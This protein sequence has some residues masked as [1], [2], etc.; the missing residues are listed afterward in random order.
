MKNKLFLYHFFHLVMALLLSLVITVIYYKAN[1]GNIDPYDQFIYGDTINASYSKLTDYR[2][3]PILFSL[4]VFSFIIFDKLKVIQNCAHKYSSVKEKLQSVK[5]NKLLNFILNFLLV[6][7]FSYLSSNVLFSIIGGEYYSIFNRNV[8]IISIMVIS[9]PLKQRAPLVSQLFFSFSPL[10]YLNESYIFNGNAIHFPPSDELSYLIYFISLITLIISI[11]NVMKNNSKINFS[12]LVFVCVTLIGEGSRVYALDEYHLGEIFTNFHQGITLNQSYY[13]EYIPTKGF[14]HTFV[15]ILNNTFYDGGYT[16]IAL[17]SKLSALIT[18]ILLLS[19]LSFFYSNLVILILL[20][21]GLPLTGNYAPILVGICILSSKR[22]MNNSYNFLIMSLFF[23]FVYFIY[24]NAFSAAFGLAIFPVLIYHLKE[25]FTHKYRPKKSHLILSI[26]GVFTF[27]ISF[28]YIIASLS[29]ILSNS[30]SNL[31][32]WGNSGTFEAL[33]T[34]NLWVLIPIALSFLIYTKVLVINR[35]NILWVCFFI[36]FPFAIL[37]YL[38]GRADGR[39][40]RALGFTFFI[41][42]M[43]FAFI[44]SKSIELNKISKCVLSAIFI[45]LLITT[46]NPVFNKIR[47]VDN[48]YHIFSI[49]HIGNNHVVI[50]KGEIPNLG[51]G[52]IEKRRYQDL[53]NEYSLISKLS[54]DET[55]LIIDGYVTQSARYSIFDKLIPTL[56]HSVLNISS[57]KAQSKE[58]VKIKKSN[59]KIIR[60]SNG[61]KRYHLFFNYF[62]SLN[63]KFI[64]FK[65]RDYLVAPELLSN[66]ENKLDFIIKSSFEQQYS[67]KQFGLL[68]IKWGN[69]LNNQLPNLKYVRV[70]EKFS[71]SNSINTSNYIDGND[72]WFAYDVNNHLEPLSLDLINLNFSINKGITCDSQLFWDDGNGFNEVKSMRF[73]I[74]NGN[75][76]IPAHMNFDWRGSD[77]IL[78]IR[79]DIDNCNKKEVSLN[80]IGAYKYNFQN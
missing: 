15:G 17:S 30:S 8:F 20:L 22:V 47:N 9:L 56:S 12:F 79:I 57:L 10:V 36:I 13:S 41:A 1:I 46:K 48:F 45:I 26:I 25:I 23:S 5:H 37:S 42:P 59:V 4:F 68:P 67:T 50:D 74:A 2:F 58:L 61:V 54:N 21:I 69:A 52:F 7:I 34:S 40:S 60:V 27:I 53:I 51:D 55:F 44:N 18:S 62:E 28:D 24:Y 16:T 39:F 38:E 43:I 65:G 77:T 14:V 66:I 63:F 3:L 76:L 72:P 71:H 73:K 11:N 49:K 70:D 78:R 33:L 75:N 64:S 29:Y 31:F 19:T 35:D 6:V 80:K 32:Y